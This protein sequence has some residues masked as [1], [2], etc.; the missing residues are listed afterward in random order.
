M[1]YE[2]RTWLGRLAWLGLT[3]ILAVMALGRKLSGGVGPDRAPSSV[4]IV[5]LDLMG[6]VV[7]GLSTAAAARR[8]WPHAYIA[9]VAPP[10]WCPIV[11]RCSAVDELIAFDP[12][13]L[14]HWPRAF[15]LAAWLD[16]L[17]TL[18]RVRQRRFD[19]AVSVYGPIAGM[20]VALS[21][22]RQ[23]VGYRSEAPPLSFDRGLTGRRING[24]A[25]EAVLATR[26]IHEADPM[27]QPVDRTGGLPSPA[28]IRGAAR[29]LIVAHAGASHGAAKRWPENHW[30]EALDRLRARTNGAIA[31]VGTDDDRPFG[32]RASDAVN[33]AIDLVG[34][35][36]LD[37]LIGV[38]R[39]ADLV[40][41]TDS[42]PAHLAR[43]LGTKVLALHGPTDVEVHGPGDPRSQAVRVDIPCGPCYDFRGPARC[44]YG[45]VLCMRWLAPTRVVDAA[46]RLL[47]VTA[48]ASA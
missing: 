18:R 44:A 3:P 27:W 20:L 23:R 40:I 28:G 17:R 37:E 21:A 48:T 34:Q 41:S 1:R 33:G 13:S 29:P 47:G 35:T 8:R 11:A 38:L 25:H 2:V 6:D 4:L 19:L 10:R 42:G 9:F 16:A 45:D 5:R 14:T 46:I 7:N 43:A 36:T 32:R 22:A 12:A 31:V 24:G 15:N 26:L 30:L 39:A